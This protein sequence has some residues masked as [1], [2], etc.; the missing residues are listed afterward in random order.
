MHDDSPSIGIRAHTPSIRIRI[1][2][3]GLIDLDSLDACMVIL[4]C[5]SERVSEDWLARAASGAARGGAG[6]TLFWSVEGPVLCW[7]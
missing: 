4:A 7:W 6:R 3:D 2:T 5:S 1:W